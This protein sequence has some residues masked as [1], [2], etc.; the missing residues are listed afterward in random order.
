MSSGRFG[1]NDRIREGTHHQSAKDMAGCIENL[2]EPGLHVLAQSFAQAEEILRFDGDDLHSYG[3]LKPEQFSQGE[4][5]RNG[6]VVGRRPREVADIR[7]F[8]KTDSSRDGIVFDDRVNDYERVVAVNDI[9]ERNSRDGALDKVHL[10]E[11]SS[12]LRAGGPRISQESD[13]MKADAV[14]AVKVIAQAKG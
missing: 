10:I 11:R 3:H 8:Q 6:D 9:Q 2:W 1:G 4:C 7:R 5:L 14:V 13:G 12:R